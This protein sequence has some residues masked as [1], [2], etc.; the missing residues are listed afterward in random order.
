MNT[1]FSLEINEKCKKNEATHM[2]SLTVV[3]WQGLVPATQDR[4]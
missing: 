4:S 2:A 3:L 1:N